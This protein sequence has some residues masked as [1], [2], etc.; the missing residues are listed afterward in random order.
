VPEA[1]EDLLRLLDVVRA[2]RTKVAAASPVA[3]HCSAGVGRTG[4][5]IALDNI[6]NAIEGRSTIVDVFNTVFRLREDRKY[7]VSKHI[8]EGVKPT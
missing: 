1:P 7:M 2:A 6:V 4:T 5:L 3:V 8:W